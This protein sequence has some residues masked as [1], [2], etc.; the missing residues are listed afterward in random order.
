MLKKGFEIIIGLV[1][2]SEIYFLLILAVIS[3]FKI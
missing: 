3:L 2:G 1:Q